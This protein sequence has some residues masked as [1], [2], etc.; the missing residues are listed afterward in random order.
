[1]KIIRFLF[2]GGWFI[3]LILSP[4]CS[5]GTPT[6]RQ[7]PEPAS[8]AFSS[9]LNEQRNIFLFE[10]DSETSQPLLTNEGENTC[11]AF[12]PDGNQIA[13]CGKRGDKNYP[14]IAGGDGSNPHIL[15]E[16]IDA[17]TCSSDAPLSWSPDGKWIVLPVLGGDPNLFGYDIFVV[18]TQR[19]TAQNLTSSPQRFGGLLWNKDSQ[20]ILITGKVGGREDIYQIDIRTKAYQPLL[21]NPI[22]GAATNWSADGSQLLL[23][24]DSG[25][26]NFDIYLL[27]KG[28]KTL[29][30]LT[31][32][33][34]F[35]SYPQWFPDGQYILFESKRDGNYEIYRMNA[36]GSEQVNLTNNPTAMDLWPTQSSDGTKIFY[37]T[38]YEDQWD[39][40]MMNA[41]GSEKR[42][43]TDLIGIPSKIAWKP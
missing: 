5:Q 26:G 40:W 41:D 2:F 21:P 17:C 9:V 19:S 36:D 34:G 32:A 14:F 11:P 20:S 42:K 35:D 22:Q 33:P 6:S 8:F 31:S 24:A 7:N 28:E 29:T 13:F 3:L 30:R 43:M 37:L 27:R 25:E 16:Q 18:D 23:F 39:S 12:S 10:L 15:T 1:M 38:S 4:A